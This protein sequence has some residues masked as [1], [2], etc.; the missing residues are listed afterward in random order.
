LYAGYQLPTNVSLTLSM[1]HVPCR[2]VGRGSNAMIISQD[3]GT[4][5]ALLVRAVLLLHVLSAAKEDSTAQQHARPMQ[6]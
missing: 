1:L 2:R 5:A 3:S 6:P 4:C